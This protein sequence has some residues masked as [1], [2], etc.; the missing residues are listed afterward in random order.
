MVV[1]ASIIAVVVIGY[2]ALVNI[3]STIF[4]VGSKIFLFELNNKY[5]KKKS[6]Q[7]FHCVYFQF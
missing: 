1:V 7:S 5:I 4:A 6:M 2:F 3:G